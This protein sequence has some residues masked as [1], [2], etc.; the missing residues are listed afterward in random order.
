[1]PLGR[2][3]AK[4]GDKLVA[5]IVDLTT[6][7]SATRERLI[8]GA[9]RGDNGRNPLFKYDSLLSRVDQADPIYK[10]IGV[11]IKAGKYDEAN[12]TIENRITDGVAMGV[13][14]QEEG[15][16]MLAFEK[17]VLEMVNVDHFPL[18]ALG[19]V[20]VKHDAPAAEKKPA[21]KK[22]KKSEETA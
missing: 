2:S 16:F 3:V 21:K 15:D 1:M 19:P 6:S 7:A 5:K 4:P 13:L 22:A 9:Y 12:L 20:S 11:A 18:E 10:K 17:D 14:T 8:T